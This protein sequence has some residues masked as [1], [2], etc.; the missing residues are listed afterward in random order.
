MSDPIRVP[1]LLTQAR[2]LAGIGAGRGRP[3]PTDH[4]RA[5]SAA[6]YALFHELNG[7]VAG[8]ALGTALASEED[9]ARVVRW[10]SHRGLKPACTQVTECAAVTVPT[11][12]PPKRTGLNDGVW[13]LFSTPSSGG[14]RVSAV[15]SALSTIVGAVIDL[16]EARHRADYDHLVDF[17]KTVARAHV[18]EAERAIDLLGAHRGDPYA[19]KLFTL[20]LARGRLGQA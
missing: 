3:S 7:C 18:E 14:Q 6:Y 15:P 5:V 13:H 17:P 2:V 11:A 16:Q 10:I 20:I 12:N 9:R 19:R 1:R 8:H 4:R